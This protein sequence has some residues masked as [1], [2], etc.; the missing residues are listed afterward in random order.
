LSSL[1]KTEV[2]VG[3]NTAELL[4]E[5]NVVLFD[6]AVKVRNVTGE[7]LDVVTHILPGTV[8]VEG[9]VKHHLFYVGTDM[10]VHHQSQEA[11]FCTYVQIPGARPHMQ[12]AVHECVESI[13]PELS[14]DGSVI[15]LK[16]V[17]GLL[18]KVTEERQLRLEPGE[19][20]LYLF[21]GVSGENTREEVNES[22]VIL[23]QPAVK[24]TDVRAEITITTAEV[25]ADKVV[26]KGSISEDVFTV[27]L[28]DNLEHHQQ[29]EL[30]FS[31]LVELPGVCSGMQAEVRAQVD[32]I[33][34]ELAAEGTELKQKTVYM[35]T[36]KVT[37][38]REL[39]LTVGE[40]LIKTRRVVGT[41]TLHQLLQ[42][43]LTLVPTA[44][45][46][47]QVS[48]AV[49]Q[50][51]TDVIAGKVIVQGVLSARIYF[52]GTDG[53]NYET[54]ERLPF[55]GYVVVAAAQPGMMAKVMPSVAGVIP[56]FDG[57]NNLLSIK[58]LLRSTVKVLQWVQAAVQEQLD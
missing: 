14:S 56:E 43:S 34:Y 55:V 15:G 20:P 12:V 42:Q 9:K 31:T 8:V 6:P 17:L 4:L 35:L 28:D 7:V 11:P 2:I 48:G 50:I 18:V 39:A 41:Q 23:S 51:S 24:V 54:E 44:Q 57:A 38:E 26:I 30:A 25:I 53:V 22:T 58:V 46:V 40:T 27:G 36:V 32:E 13:L 47:N 29:E 52:T 49:T 37:E 1:V 21:P 33:K 5:T 19:G 16:T 10:V 45:K 3:E